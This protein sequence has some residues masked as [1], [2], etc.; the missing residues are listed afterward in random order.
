MT[1]APVSADPAADAAL[2]AADATEAELGSEVAEDIKP[3]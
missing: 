1:D 2:A 3:A